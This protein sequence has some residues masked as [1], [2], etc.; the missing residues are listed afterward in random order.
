MPT[1]KGFGRFILVKDKQRD[2]IKMILPSKAADFARHKS[3]EIHRQE[4]HAINTALHQH[5]PEEEWE[6]GPY[7][8]RVSSAESY[9]SSEM[10][11]RVRERRYADKL[12]GLQ[13][14]VEHQKKECKGDESAAYAK[15]AQVIQ[16]GK[17]L[18]CEHA[19]GH[20][21]S[22][23]EV[24]EARFYRPLM[25][26]R[27]LA[28]KEARERRGL[29][30][31]YGPLLITEDELKV[32]LDKL[33]SSQHGR[34][35]K[36]L[37]KHNLMKRSC[38][39]DDACTTRVTRKVKHYF[40]YDPRAWQKWRRVAMWEWSE[41]AKEGQRTQVRDATEE[42]T[43]HNIQKCSNRIIIKGPADMEGL[44]Q[45]LR[46]T[47]LREKGGWNAGDNAVLKEILKLAES[48]GLR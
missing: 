20:V 9:S 5:P 47:H 44:F 15:C 29:A 14:W 4:R 13:R 34:L 39:H 7:Y 2:L 30:K 33:Y 16:P 11:Y 3:R 22:W 43:D 23:L 12:G 24:P 37:K 41:A 27:D 25:N 38:T 45:R 1:G 48:A 10:P 36:I 19:M 8:R 21:A 32:L 42:M 18:I 40:I 28:A 6:D 31:H 35:N 17:N 46:G 26:E